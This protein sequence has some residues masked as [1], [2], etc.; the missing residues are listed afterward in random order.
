MTIIPTRRHILITALGS[1]A[2]VGVSLAT[3]PA[4]A[5]RP[6]AAIGG[7]DPVAYFTRGRAVPGEAALTAEAAG[8]N[9]RFASAAH[10][11]LFLADPARYLPRYAARCAWAMAQGYVAPVD[12]RQWHIVDGTLYLNYDAGVHRRWL[13]DIAGHI[14]RADANWPRFQ[15]TT[16]FA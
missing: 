13:A 6:A 16:P 9:W 7:Y 8:A 4:A 15:A 14:R 11:D 5:R 12:P 10:R 1:A 3:I 2:A